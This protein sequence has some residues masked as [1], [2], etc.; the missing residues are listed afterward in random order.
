MARPRLGLIRMMFRISPEDIA[1]MDRLGIKNRNAFVREAIRDG[2]KKLKE[3]L[4]RVKI[5]QG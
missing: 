2:L 5:R 3:Q 4:R 1:E